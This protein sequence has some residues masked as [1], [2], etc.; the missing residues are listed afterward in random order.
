MRIFILLVALFLAMATQAV[1]ADSSRFERS[2]KTLALPERLEQLC[3]YTAMSHIRESA[4]FRPDRAVAGAITE[5][6]LKGDTIAASGAAFRSGRKW[7]ALSFTCTANPEHLKVLNFNF[8]IG[9]EIPES[10]WTN[11]GLW[12]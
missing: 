11:Y 8:T 10:K 5:P 9:E 2:L 4:N 12:D 6:R 3:D 1:A 7:Y